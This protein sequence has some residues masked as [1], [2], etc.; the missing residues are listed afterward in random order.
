MDMF[1]EVKEEV[2]IKRKSGL[3]LGWFIQKENEFTENFI[4][5]GKKNRIAL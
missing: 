2:E 4:T 1:R 3:A 5:E